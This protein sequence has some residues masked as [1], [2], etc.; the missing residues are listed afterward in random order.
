MASLTLAA[1]CLLTSAHSPGS[2]TW[3]GKAVGP[4]LGINVDD[5]A[6][7]ARIKELLNYWIKTDVL[8]VEE[9]ENPRAGRAVK[10][11]VA[12]QNNPNSTSQG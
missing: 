2:N 5:A 3:A 1:S 4:I 8:A 11:I 9:R 12:G 10:V 7:Y 6:G